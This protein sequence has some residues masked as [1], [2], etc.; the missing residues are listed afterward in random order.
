[1]DNGQTDRNNMSANLEQILQLSRHSRDSRPRAIEQHYKLCSQMAT[2]YTPLYYVDDSSIP[3]F[4]VTY[5]FPGQ[6]SGYFS[7]F[8]VLYGQNRS[9]KPFC[10]EH[11]QKYNTITAAQIL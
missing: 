1:M 5:L 9:K 7:I 3:C 11:C 4:N 6:S 10:C 8:E 2:C